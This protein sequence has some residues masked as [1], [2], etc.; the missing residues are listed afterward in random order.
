MHVSPV[1]AKILGVIHFEF[2]IKSSITDAAEIF[3][4][5]F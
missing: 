2:A 1:A 5:S 4:L 3:G